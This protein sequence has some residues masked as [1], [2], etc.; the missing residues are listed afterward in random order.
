VADVLGT[1]PDETAVPLKEIGHATDVDAKDLA[2][3]AE[4]F[5]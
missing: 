1:L 5:Y 3:A 2:E 4:C